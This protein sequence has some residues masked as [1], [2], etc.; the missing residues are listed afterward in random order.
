MLSFSA[1]RFVNR[2]D[3]DFSL[4]SEL[5]ATQE[6]ELVED[7][8]ADVDYPVK[9]AVPRHN[10]RNVPLPPSVPVSFALPTRLAVG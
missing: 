2:D 4:A 10:L 5:P 3:I 9:Y 1:L 8:T 6:F 7:P